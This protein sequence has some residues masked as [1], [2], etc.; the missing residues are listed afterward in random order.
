LLL[1]AGVQ[2]MQDAKRTN[3]VLG[4]WDWLSREIGLVFKGYVRNSQV[5]TVSFFSQLEAKQKR[6][7]SV[8]KF[9]LWS[10]TFIKKWSA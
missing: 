4:N 5:L 8:I 1:L 10:Q 3:T 2:E 6:C 9:P 7:H